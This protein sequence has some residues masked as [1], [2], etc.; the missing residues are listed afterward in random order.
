MLRK[1]W[2]TTS[3]FFQRK[4]KSSKD[5]RRSRRRRLSI[6]EHLERRELLT[7]VSWIGGSGDWNVGANWSNGV[8]PTAA[9]DAVIDV[10][11]SA[12]T[13]THSSG[14]HT[15]ASITMAET[16]RLTE[17][18]L[19][20]SH[21]VAGSGVL[22]I[23]GGTLQDATVGLSNPVIATSGNMSHITMNSAFDL[24]SGNATVGISNSFTLNNIATINNGALY[25]NGTQTLGGT[26][27]VNM[28]GS[29]AALVLNQNNT[30]MTVG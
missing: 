16:V 15:I 2:L 25:F 1:N 19:I 5:Q 18:T 21:Q 23:A 30:T 6:F 9:D 4:T 11:G 20:V 29:I 26:G 24:T 14:T 10:P 13:I 17:G 27:T 22:A 8:G 3:I 7:T 12:V 28:V